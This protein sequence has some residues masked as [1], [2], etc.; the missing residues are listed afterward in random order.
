M[1]YFESI[2]VTNISEYISKIMDIRD[3]LLEEGSSE[4]LFFRG[5]C[6]L[7][8]DI[9]PSIFRNSWISVEE[10]M[11][12]KAISRVP[13]EFAGCNTAFEELTKLQHYGLPT[14]LL[15][16]TMNPL[17]A[18]YFACCSKEK[19]EGEDDSNGVVYYGSSYAR[20][21]SDIDVKI[22]SSLAKIK[23]TSTTTLND[24]KVTLQLNESNPEHLINTIQGDLFVM[25]K[26][27]NSRLV[28]QSGAFLLVGA[29]NIEEDKDNIWNSRIRK[30]FHNM[31]SAFHSE[32]IIIPE[33]CKAHILDEL[34]FYNINEA[35]L[36]PELEHQMSH[37][38]HVGMQ[39]TESV[40]PFIKFDP[41]MSKYVSCSGQTE[42]KKNEPMDICGIVDRHI[43]SKEIQNIVC[44]IIQK[45][46]GFP[47]WYKKESTVSA[48]KIDLKRSL[49]CKES[50][51]SKRIV[52][53]LISDLRKQ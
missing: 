45:Y 25:P 36:F 16:V 1:S 3:G 18:L 6:N 7:S 19:L 37:I 30:S 24:L 47:D 23:L 21:S 52:E 2:E 34:D 40:A 49:N 44:D 39:N 8:W 13:H 26:Y 53:Q 29:I 22:L 32:R 51:D 10:E 5:Q 27:S 48:L 35:S 9:R 17:V 28:S 50:E 14:R 4:S 43:R 31:N 41:Y 12:E 38:K 46:I 11:I 20:H 42:E 15:D 33:E